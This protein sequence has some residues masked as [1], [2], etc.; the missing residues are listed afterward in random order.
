RRLVAVVFGGKT[1]KSR[2][3][4]MMSLLDRGFIKAASLPRFSP[5]PTP[6]KPTTLLAAAPAAND[7]GP[8]VAV[9]EVASEETAEGEDVGSMLGLIRQAQAAN[10]TGPYGVQVGAFF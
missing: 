4:H 5:D 2:D 1:S 8:Q 10:V 9:E 6:P 3:A 7:A